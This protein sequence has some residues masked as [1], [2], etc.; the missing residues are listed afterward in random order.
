MARYKELKLWSA[1]H[2]GERLT[3]MPGTIVECDEDHAAWVNRDGN[4]G[5]LVEDKPTPAA[6][7]VA[8]PPNN[9]MIGAVVTPVK[10]GPGRPPK[11]HD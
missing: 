11:V 1:L 5:V 8:E 2:R 10:R 6:R 9:R 7:Q 3:Y 4:G